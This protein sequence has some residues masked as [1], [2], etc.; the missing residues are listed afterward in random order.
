MIKA[1]KTTRKR[2]VSFEEGGDDV[3]RGVLATGDQVD[4]KN[5]C[6]C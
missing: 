1:P 2:T 6:D 4:T 3:A 5:C